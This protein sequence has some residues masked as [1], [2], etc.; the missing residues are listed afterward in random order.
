[1]SKWMGFATKLLGMGVLLGVY[2][3]LRANQNGHHANKRV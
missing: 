2:K 1:M 3:A